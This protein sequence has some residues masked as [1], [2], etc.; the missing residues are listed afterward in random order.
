MG[1]GWRV[2]PGEGY[3][4]AGEL[5]T[6]PK[7][8]KSDTIIS[9]ELVKGM[10]PTRSFGTH[11]WDV[12]GLIVVAG[13]PNY[14]GAPLLT[15]TA[16]ARSGAGIVAVVAPRSIVSAI[17][18]R[19]PEAIFLPIPDGEPQ[20]YGKKARELVQER[21]E[22]ARALVVGPGIG[23]DEHAVA[24]MSTLCGKNGVTRGSSIGFASF[25]RAAD[26]GE[27]SAGLIG[28]DKPTV[29]DADGLNWLAEQSDWWLQFAPQSIVLTPHVGEMER[30]TGA[31]AKDIVADPVGTAKTAAAKWKQVVVLKYGHSIVTDGDK[32]FVAPDAPPS[33]ATAGA[34]DVLAGMVGGFLAQGLSP[35]DASTVA[36]F[37]GP[38]AARR[39]ETVTGTLGLLA[40]DLPLAIA[41][42]LRDLEQA[43]GVN[44][45]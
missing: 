35:L 8:G 32:V 37:I 17:A 18:T 33:L 9:E 25:A 7:M 44:R 38:R 13:A 39:V 28:G 14:Y 4:L 43:K 16:A 27:Q 29:L 31:A 24:L 26:Q 19:L 40:G 30:L 2:A 3:S 5:N 20:S 15:A 42:E 1:R 21:F 41:E 36:L 10:L 45:A 6:L 12:G 23:Q 11:K 34:G 22:K